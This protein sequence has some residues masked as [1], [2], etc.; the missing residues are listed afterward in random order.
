MKKLLAFIS[1][2]VA[3]TLVAADFSTSFYEK[4]ESHDFTAADSI[5]AAWS[6]ESPDDPEIYPARFNLCLNKARN[7]TIVL[8][9][10]PAAEG[11]QLVLRDS[12]NEDAGYVYSETSWNDSLV[13]QAFV[14]I[15]RGIAACPDRIDFRL[16]KAALGSRAEHW[17]KTVDALDAMIERD[18]ENGGRW[19][20]AENKALADADTLMAAAVYDRF[21]EMFSKAPDP[22]LEYAIPLVAKTAKRFSGDIR[23]VNMAGSI[24]FG[25]GNFEDAGAYFE[26][27]SRLDPTDGIPRLNIAYL[28]YQK[29]D[30]AKALEIYREL[31][32]GEYDEE[33]K[34]S[35]AQM[36]AEITAPVE[37]M[38][39]YYYFFNYLPQIASLAERPADCLDIEKI[40]TRIP[41]RIKL[42]SPFAD[43][44]IKAEEVAID[45]TGRSVVAWTFPMPEDVPMCLYVAFVHDDQGACRL[46]TLEKS[47]DDIWIVGA[48]RD[49]TSLHRNFGDIPLPADAKA[50]V[51]PLKDKKLVK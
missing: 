26:E 9:G 50:F 37:D 51:Q 20:G 5:L 1:L 33:T 12:T 15:D 49:R 45:D 39:E 3:L 21:S 10:E 28:N 48:G 6:S 40:N 13:S 31:E 11:E 17:D 44:D 8:S 32:A 4:L 35:A 47:F 38:T 16:G 34:S 7:E 19:F 14:E 36:I 29:G 25:L 18:K 30:T 22:V 43:T 2:A 27:A 41:A 46:Y 42:R 24:N 23:V